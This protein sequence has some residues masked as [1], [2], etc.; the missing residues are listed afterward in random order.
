MVDNFF[1]WIRLGPKYSFQNQ[2]NIKWPGRKPHL[3]T[4]NLHLVVR[5][6]RREAGDQGFEHRWSRSARKK[7]AL[8]PLALEP[9]TLGVTRSSLNHSTYKTLLLEIFVL[10][11][12]CLSNFEMS[13]WDPKRIQIKTLSTTKFYNFSR[14]TTLVLVVSPSEV[15]WKIQIL[16]LENSEVIILS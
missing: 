5:G 15:V 8:Q 6:W 10:A 14:S 2:M 9:M 7:L 16:N 4:N 13:I 12:L 1:I 11:I 3:D